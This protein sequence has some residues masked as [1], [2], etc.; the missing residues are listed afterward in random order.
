[1]KD[2]GVQNYPMAISLK[3]EHFSYYASVAQ[4]AGA[5]EY[6]DWFS[7]EKLDPPPNECPV[8]DTKQ[9][10]GEILVMLELWGMQSNPFLYIA[11]RF[12]LAISGSTW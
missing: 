12:T 2:K 8:Y 10:D 6:T 3:V 5:V 1:M 9:S 11:A 4:S 7:A